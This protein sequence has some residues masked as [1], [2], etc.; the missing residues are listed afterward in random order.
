MINDDFLAKCKSINPSVE[1]DRK[2]NLEAIQ[3]R[4][5]KEEEQA[6]MLNNKK[7]RKPAVAAV[8]LAGIL[9]LSVATYAAAPIIWRYFDTNVVQG[10]EFVTNFFMGEV[11]LPDG[12]T[13]IGGNLNIDRQALEAAGG[14]VIIVEADGEEWVVLDELHLDSLQDG[15]DMLQLNNVLLPSELPEGFTFSRFTFPVNP[16]NHDYKLGSIPAAEAAFIHYN[17]EDGADFIIQVGSMPD[18]MTLGI[19]DGQQGLVINGKQ[20]VLSGPALS[21]AQLA[22]LE[23][24]TLFEGHAFDDSLGTVGGSSR[25]DE[26]ISRIMLLHNGVLYGISTTCPQ[27]SAYELVS[28]VESMR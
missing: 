23:N 24:V 6:I 7:I 21:E 9:S 17:N 14:G 4:L 22:A 11:D 19:L 25:F 12:T 28:L 26:Y 10:E 13:S 16:N 2:R 1:I 15:M 8:L 27:L 3:N 5:L 18:N 20:A